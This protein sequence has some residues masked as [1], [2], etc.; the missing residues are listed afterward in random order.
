MSRLESRLNRLQNFISDRIS[1]DA[2]IRHPMSEYERAARVIWMVNHPDKC[3][4][5]ALKIVTDILSKYI[6]KEVVKQ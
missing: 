4:P 2:R 1:D 6:P 5:K 3:D